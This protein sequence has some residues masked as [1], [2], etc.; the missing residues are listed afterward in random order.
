MFS[1]REYGPHFFFQTFSFRYRL[2]TVNIF[3][4]IHTSEKFQS[5]FWYFKGILK[6][7]TQISVYEHD[8]PRF[9]GMWF[10]LTQKN[11][12]QMFSSSY[13]LF[14]YIPKGMYPKYTKVQHLLFYLYHVASK[15]LIMH[16]FLCI[17]CSKLWWAQSKLLSR[18]LRFKMWK[19]IQEQ[20]IERKL[21]TGAPKPVYCLYMLLHGIYQMTLNMARENR[22]HEWPI[23]CTDRYLI[24]L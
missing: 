2:L 19:H 22:R 16:Q 21:H 5:L 20:N 7:H 1:K 24:I 12:I 15:A 11:R 3:K 6:S 8:I 23:Q 18:W 4:D 10:K 13:F 9:Q 17:W 14:V